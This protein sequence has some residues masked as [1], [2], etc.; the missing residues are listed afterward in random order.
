MS[1]NISNVPGMIYPTQKAPLAGNPRDSAIAQMGASNNKLNAL[2]K[3]AGGNRVKK[4]GQTS[5]GNIVVPQ[6]KSTY[7][8]QSGQGTGTNAQIAGLLKTSTQG[9]ANAQYDSYAT[10]KKG[11]SRRKTKGRKGG[12]PNW[13]WPCSSGGTRKRKYKGKKGGSKWPCSSGG[14]RSYKK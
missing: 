10:A 7:T 2:N 1:N 3:L 12:N 8:E 6:F 11:G 5:S 14:K 9:A 4:G 13:K